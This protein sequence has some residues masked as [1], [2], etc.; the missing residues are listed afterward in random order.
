MR[1]KRYQLCMIT[2]PAEPSKN[3]KF[4]VY[5]FFPVPHTP[6]QAVFKLSRAPSISVRSMIMRQLKYSRP[7]PTTLW[8]DI[9]LHVLQNDY[10]SPS[11]NN[12]FFFWNDSS[13]SSNNYSGPVVLEWQLWRTLL[14][15]KQLLLL[16]SLSNDLHCRQFVAVIVHDNHD[17]QAFL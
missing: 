17:K 5:R 3:T 1:R 12:N 11:S 15:V 8:D 16:D 6:I 13:S 7:F 14:Q 4:R 9:L 2:R 10:S